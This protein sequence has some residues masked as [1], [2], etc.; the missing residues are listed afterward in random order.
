MNPLKIIKA[1]ADFH[2]TRREWLG[3]DGEF[4]NADDAQKRADTCLYGNG[5][6]LCPHN[7]EMPLFEVLTHAAA[8]NVIAQLKVKDKL[9]LR[10]NRE[11]E[12]HTCAVCLCNLRLKPFVPSKFIHVSFRQEEIPPWCWMHELFDKNSTQEL[13]DNENSE[14]PKQ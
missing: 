9:G 10:L 6:K 3:G 12:L 4:I 7:Q 14:L 2:R 13:N 1:A 11:N 5:G 8:R